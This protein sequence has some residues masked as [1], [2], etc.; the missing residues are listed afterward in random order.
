MVL[1]WYPS[2]LLFFSPFVLSGILRPHIHLI[3]PVICKLISQLQDIGTQTVSWQARA[4]AT[5]RR[6]C[7]SARG[8]VVEQS[9]VVVS[10]TVHC[11]TRT[12]TIALNGEWYVCSI[13]Y[14][15]Q[16]LL[17]LPFRFTNPFSFYHN[18]SVLILAHL[19]E[20]LPFL[21]ALLISASLS[22]PSLSFFFSILLLPYLP[23]SSPLYPSLPVSPLNLL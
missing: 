21:T 13:I 10:R 4:V 17:P 6:I 5:L 19:S 22:F 7:T 11:L 20:K 14:T 8:A 23:F 16:L 1:T 9:L 12:V 2:S 3:V 18:F 15:E